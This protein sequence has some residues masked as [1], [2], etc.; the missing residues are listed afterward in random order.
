MDPLPVGRPP[1]KTAMIIHLSAR[2]LRSFSRDP[3]G[4]GP[5]GLRHAPSLG[6]PIKEE[7]MSATEIL[8]ILALVAWSVYRQ[9]RTS[10]V[11]AKSRFKMAIIYTIVGLCVGGFDRPSGLIGYGMIAI[12]LALSPVVGLARGRLTRVRA[13][14]EGRVFSQGT[15]V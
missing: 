1:G 9:T 4:P 14:A 15:V 2:A 5:A 8:A 13:D 3:G 12:G 7:H 6:A 11:T 10:Q